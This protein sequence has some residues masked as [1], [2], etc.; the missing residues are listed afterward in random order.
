MRAAAAC[1]DVGSVKAGSFGWAYRTPVELDPIHMG[2]EPE[3]FCRE[4]AELLNQG[5]PVALGFECP[6]FVPLRR[7]AVDL[8]RG[9]SG[10]GNR[11]WSAGAG[12]GALAVGLVQVP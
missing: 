1:V 9:R 11:A 6:L 4:V 7:A 10:E 5:L 2:N 3:T 8:L 12:S